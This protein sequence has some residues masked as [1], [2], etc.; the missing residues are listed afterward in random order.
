MVTT[1]SSQTPQAVV[2]AV[3]AL[4]TRP[5]MAVY[6][7]AGIHPERQLPAEV[8]LEVRRLAAAVP[9]MLAASAT[10]CQPRL[11]PPA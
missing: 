2:A 4:V 10:S 7:V 3:A 6:A 1:G 11:S 9:A 8:V 5:G